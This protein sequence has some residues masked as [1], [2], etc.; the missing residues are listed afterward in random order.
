MATTAFIRTIA[1]SYRPPSTSTTSD[2]IGSIR[3][4]CTFVGMLSRQEN[5]NIG[6]HFRRKNYRVAHSVLWSFMWPNSG[7]EDTLKIKTRVLPCHIYHHFLFTKLQSSPVPEPAFLQNHKYTQ[8]H[9]TQLS[10]GEFLVNIQLDRLLVQQ[11]VQLVLMCFSLFQATFP[12]L[13]DVSSRPNKILSAHKINVIS[14]SSSL[15]NT[16]L[17]SS[18]A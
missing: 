11:L 18:I 4:L 9:P 1:T 15:F 10:F 8:F 2:R 7:L 16:T 17:F 5:P 3:R 13:D 6:A 12:Q 14:F